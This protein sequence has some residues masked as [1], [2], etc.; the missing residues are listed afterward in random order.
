MTDQVPSIRTLRAN[1]KAIVYWNFP[2][3][4]KVRVK[5]DGDVQLMREGNDYWS[6]EGN[7]LNSAIQRLRP[8]PLHSQVTYEEI[9]E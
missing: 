8:G 1:V 2:E 9:D 4:T 3:G 6:S 7:L 5:S